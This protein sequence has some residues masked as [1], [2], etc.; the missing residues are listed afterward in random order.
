[1]RA[2]VMDSTGVVHHGKYMKCMSWA[3]CCAFFRCRRQAQRL[4]SV[5]DLVDSEGDVQNEQQEAEKV[6]PV[7]DSV[8]SDDDNHDAPCPVDW[9]EGVDEIDHY[10]SPEGITLP[11]TGS[12]DR[13]G[14]IGAWVYKDE[15]GDCLNASVGYYYDGDSVGPSCGN[16]VATKSGLVLANGSGGRCVM[17]REFIV[18][19][20]SIAPYW[21]VLTTH[22]YAAD[23]TDGQSEYALA[24]DTTDSKG[25]MIYVDATEAGGISRFMSHTYNAKARFVV[26]RSRC[27]LVMMVVA[28]EDI[29][30]GEEVT[31]WYGDDLWFMCM[32]GAKNFVSLLPKIIVFSR[33]NVQE[34]IGV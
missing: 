4:P 1:M 21:G 25:H 18:A 15:G 26:R 16:R 32:C 8:S 13:V 27:S 2:A 11:D 3:V 10:K 33:E 12:V 29:Q 30:P 5:V 20:T 9:P 6:I 28:V 22:N 34:P 14:C 24:T 31:L 23:D 19:G 7:I 17:T